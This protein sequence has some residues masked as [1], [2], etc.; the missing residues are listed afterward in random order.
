M[1]RVSMGNLT[2]EI[3]DR[4]DFVERQFCVAKEGVTCMDCGKVATEH[5]YSCGSCG[6][7]GGP[8]GSECS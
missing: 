2:D 4:M 3:M 6:E 1:G 5:E 7:C 8:I